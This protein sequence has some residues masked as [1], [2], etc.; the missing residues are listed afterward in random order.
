MCI[1][2]R[3]G[4][5]HGVESARAAGAGVATPG[6]GLL[7]VSVAFG[8]EKILGRPRGTWQG[9]QVVGYEIHHGVCHVDPQVLASGSAETFLDGCR[10]GSVWGTLWHGAMEND[11]FRRA[12]LTQVAASSGSAWRPRDGV[13]GFADRRE[14]MIDALADAVESHL[15]L[16]ALL[17]L[18]RPR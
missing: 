4:D 5:E 6:L 12:W 8:A 15:D 14:A 18:A 16:D 10:V 13:P 3:I 11:A 7:P 1:R 9:T 2:D 17:A